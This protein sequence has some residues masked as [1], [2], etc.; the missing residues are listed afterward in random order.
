[1]ILGFFNI[2]FCIYILGF[3]AQSFEPPPVCLSIKGPLGV[4]YIKRDSAVISV[5]GE[6]LHQYRLLPGSM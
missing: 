1:M 6:D 5:C 2:A 3:L 4:Q